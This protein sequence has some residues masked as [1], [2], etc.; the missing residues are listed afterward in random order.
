MIIST[1]LPRVQQFMWQYFIG[2]NVNRQ[3]V[4]II[5]KKYLV[6]L[7]LLTECFYKKKPIK[8]YIDTYLHYISTYELYNRPQGMIWIL[9]FPQNDKICIFSFFKV[10]SI[11]KIL[12]KIRQM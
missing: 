6:R 7:S 12:N 1:Y 2:V 8:Y 10:S 5:W 9:K 4:N 11:L 3:L